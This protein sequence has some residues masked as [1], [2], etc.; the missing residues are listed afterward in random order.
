MCT[1]RI[2]VEVPHH[3]D[4][5]PLSSID[6][7]RLGDLVHQFEYN[8]PHLEYEIHH[9]NANFIIFNTNLGIHSGFNRL[10]LRLHQNRP[11]SVQSRPKLLDLIL[12]MLGFMQT[13][14]PESSLNAAMCVTKT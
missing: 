9:L 4:P 1:H 2:H 8:F 12:K 7:S 6:R 10:K 3:D 13:C 11:N 14:E 5:N